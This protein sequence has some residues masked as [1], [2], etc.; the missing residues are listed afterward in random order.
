M[1][2]FKEKPYVKVLISI[3]YFLTVTTILSLF[4]G[5]IFSKFFMFFVF[6]VSFIFTFIF[7]IVV[8]FTETKSK[9]TSVFITY[10]EEKMKN[11]VTIE[12]YTE[13][14]NEFMELSVKDGIFILAYPKTLNRII[15]KIETILVLLEKIEEEK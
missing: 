3:L 13:I 6:V 7:A 11:A 14:R 10:I 12:E 8:L 9:Y 15:L 4:I 5:I 1:E 2:P